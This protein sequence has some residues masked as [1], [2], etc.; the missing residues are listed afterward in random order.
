MKETINPIIHPK[1]VN[2]NHFP[3]KPAGIRF[4]SVFMVLLL[5]FEVTSRNLI[6]YLKI[7]L[8]SYDY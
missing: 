3:K 8:Y 4:G 6:F 5:L 1:L 7:D 2:N